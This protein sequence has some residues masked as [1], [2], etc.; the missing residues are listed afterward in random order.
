ML[1]KSKKGFTLLEILVVVAIIGLVSSVIFVMLNNARMKARDSKRYA[2]VDALKK[3]LE[4][5]YHDNDQYPEAADN[6]IKIEDDANFA[7]A[8]Q[9]YISSIPRDP[10]YPR[11]EGEKVFSYQ[12][13]STADAQGYKFHIEMET[14]TYVE[15]SYEVFVGEGI[16]IE[17][18]DTTPPVRSNGAP[19]GTLPSGTTNTTI[20]LQ[21]NENATC[22]YDII[23]GVAY[24]DMPN[25]FAGAGT[26]NHLDTVTGLTN[27]NTYN[28]Y[29]RCEDGAGN[30]NPD[31]FLIT[32]DVAAMAETF[33]AGIAVESDDSEQNVGTGAMSLSSSDLELRNLGNNDGYVGMRW[34]GVTIPQGS[35][36]DSAKIQ[37]Q[38]DEADAAVAL[39]V[40]FRGE[41]IDDAPTFTTTTSNLSDRTETTASINWAIPTWG[42]IGARGPDQLTSDLKT[43]VQEIV[44]RPG[45]VSGNDLVIMIKAWSGNG[46]RVAEAG[47]GADSAEI[48][49]DWS[50]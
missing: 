43:I 37:F 41:D 25:T 46:D 49:I 36:I 4:L 16:D 9:P 8:M 22:R 31:D 26:Q 19:T 39:T 47:P 24:A 10:L 21:T 27:G 13:Q 17:Y 18:T 32:F 38:V 44:D 45:W 11:I 2:E 14:G 1:K 15:I 12:Y 5:Y 6:W 50:P 40:T 28:Y 42:T 35:T 30:A 33:V 20:S 7:T 48:T 34:T 3:A 29:V 23:S